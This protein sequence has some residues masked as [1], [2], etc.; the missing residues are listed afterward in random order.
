M[1]LNQEQSVVVVVLF[2]GAF[3]RR[4]IIFA[5]LKM[6]AKETDLGI[7]FNMPNAYFLHAPE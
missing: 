6:L 3:H 2:N 4:L 7:G 5:S 1:N